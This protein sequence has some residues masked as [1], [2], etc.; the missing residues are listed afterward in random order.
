MRLCVLL[1][2]IPAAVC[3]AQ[4]ELSLSRNDLDRRFAAAKSSMRA[5]KAAEAAQDFE[6]IV[7]L[8]P[9]FAKAY[10]A[11]GVCYTQLG[12][13]DEAITALQSYLKLEPKSPNGHALLGMLLLYDGR[14]AEA[15][16]VLEQALRLDRS[17]SEAVKALGCIYNLDGNN[18]KAIALL[19]PLVESGAADDETRTILSRALL[20][21]GDPAAAVKI[22]DAVL[23]ANPHCPLQT[24]VLAAM[25]ARDAHNFPKAFEICERGAAVYSNSEQL[26]TLAVSFPPEALIARTTQHLREI[27]KNPNEVA[28]LIAVGRIMIAKDKGERAADLDL[29]CELL[30]RAT[31]LDPENAAAWFHYGRCFK[32]QIGKADEAEAAFNRALSFVHDDELR[33][34]ILEQLG[35]MEAH[36]NRIAAADEAFRKSL[37]LNRKLVRHI[38][39]SAYHYYKFLA[40][41]ERDA[42]EHALLDEILRWDPLFAP[43]LLERAK[44]FMSNEQLEKAAIDALLVT[45]NFEDPE[46]LRSAHYLL[47]RIYN[48]T[49]NKTQAQ[50][51]IDWLKSHQQAAEEGQPTSVP[52][53]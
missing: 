53:R 52:L 37:E 38:P 31:R 8:R 2:L 49:G 26:E 40:L 21:S 23:A 9:D 13:F 50:I 10:F 14:I 43:A 11:L 35:S 25:A 24:Y 30:A 4:G 33:V 27:E 16:P 1:M 5:G 20:S 45:R 32:A 46:V 19:R 42:E 39:E 17:Q 41:R 48:M 47:L 36:S 34:L 18:T 28:A 12:K 44:N 22:L 7:R 29:G 51:H 3:A 15:R 6:K